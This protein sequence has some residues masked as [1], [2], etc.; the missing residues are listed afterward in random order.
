MGKTMAEK[1]TSEHWENLPQKLE[2][3]LEKGRVIIRR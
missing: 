1:T 2:V 3:D